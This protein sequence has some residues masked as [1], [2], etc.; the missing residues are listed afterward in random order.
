MK[1]TTIINYDALW[2]RIREYARKAGRV[3]TRPMLLLFYVLKSRDTPWKDKML[4]LSTL[5]YII[6]PVDI[7]NAKRLP[8]IGWFDEIAS[9][10][11]TYQKV[12]RNITPEIEANVDAIL[13][14]WFP[15]YT[16]FEEVPT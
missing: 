10:S 6:L 8:I 9:L 13:D 12:C 2:G 7:L 4:I 3:A 1:E 16:E 5:S 11:V 15:E 14:K